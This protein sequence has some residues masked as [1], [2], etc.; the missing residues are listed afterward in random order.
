MTSQMP[1]RGNH[2]VEW[3][4]D[5]FRPLLQEL[6][7]QNI[8]STPIIVKTTDKRNFIIK[9]MGRCIIGIQRQSLNDGQKGYCAFIHHKELNLF[10]LSIVIDESLFLSDAFDLRVQ[11]KALAIHEFVH[12]VAIMLSLSLLGSGPNPLIESLKKILSERLTVT[13]SDD[14]NQLLRA[15]GTLSETKDYKRLP[16][17]NDKHFRTGFE[18][19]P[20][21]YA[22]LYLNFL[23]SYKLLREVVDSDK[24][25][26][27]KSLII[28]KASVH[29]I[30]FL[31]DVI[32]EITETKALEKEFVVQRFLYFLPRL[33]EE[34]LKT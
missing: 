27:F 32:S 13:T 31:N 15:L 8:N 29:L 7:V 21:D 23:F 22:D 12:C 25:E 34:L 1:S 10:I 17:F 4:V 11:R 24:L 20:D 33:S 2:N 14:F 28:S 5:T 6:H 9:G 19:F 16:L 18:D 30:D 3:A 26:T